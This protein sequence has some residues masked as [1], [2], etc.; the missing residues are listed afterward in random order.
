MSI[1]ARWH[2]KTWGVSPDQVK[3]LADL[4]ISR[5]LKADKNTSLE[6]APATNERG[7]ELM[8]VSFSMDLY[9]VAGVDVRAEMDDWMGLI[10][11]KAYLYLDNKKFGAYLQ[12]KDVKVSNILLDD[13]GRMLGAKLTCSM[14]EVD[15]ADGVA[16]ESGPG[17]DE[18]AAMKPRN[19]GMETSPTTEIGIGAKVQIVGDRYATGETV[20]LWVR[21]SRYTIAQVKGDRALVQPVNSWVY[22]K[23]LSLVVT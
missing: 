2:T 21:E 3:V 7:Y 14:E 17:Q 12:L 4:T 22:T 23:D 8:P 19:I 15:N 9:R 20:P 13:Y 5:K 18:K 1:M 10:G 6:H 11:Q 16:D